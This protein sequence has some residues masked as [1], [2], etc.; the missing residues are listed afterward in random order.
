M[1]VERIFGVSCYACGHRFFQ[2]FHYLDILRR[3]I[4]CLLLPKKSTVDSRSFQGVQ[5]VRRL[6]LE[7]YP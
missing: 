5:D 7:K 4:V 1:D 2:K 6:K 3:T